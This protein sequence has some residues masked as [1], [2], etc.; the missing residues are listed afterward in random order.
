[1]NQR[2]LGH[3]WLVMALAAGGFGFLSA[4]VGT[5]VHAQSDPS[6]QPRPIPPAPSPGPPIEPLPPSPIPPPTPKPIPP[7]PPTDPQMAF[8]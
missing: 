4:W 2:R 6:Q 1:M 3:V 8:S 7:A 5:P